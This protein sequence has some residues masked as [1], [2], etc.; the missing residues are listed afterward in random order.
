MKRLY[1]T[2]G[3]IL[4]VVLFGWLFGLRLNESSAIPTI[5]EK[6]ESAGFPLTVLEKREIA[7]F[8][9]AEIERGT[10][11]EYKEKGHFVIYDFASIEQR[12]EAVNHFK[13]IY[14]ILS[15]I[16]PKMYVSDRHIV[17]FW[18]H[19]NNIYAAEDINHIHY[20][21]IVKAIQGEEIIPNDIFQEV[22]K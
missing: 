9:G 19:P 6:I 7:D 5:T 8:Y 10:S 16:P 14:P 21:A 4:F 12:D 18:G 3:I 2:I 1:I 22:I 20:E 13:K 11:Y 15:S 17:A